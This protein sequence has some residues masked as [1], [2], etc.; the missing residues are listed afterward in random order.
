MYLPRMRCTHGPFSP[1]M[2]TKISAIR[3]ARPLR[4]WNASTS[5]PP[6]R[7]T[8]TSPSTGVSCAFLSPETRRTSPSRTPLVRRWRSRDDVSAR[9]CERSTP[10][11]RASASR[12]DIREAR[13]GEGGTRRAGGRFILLL[14]KFIL[15]GLTPETFEFLHH[16]IRK[17]RHLG[18]FA[19]LSLLWARALAGP[20]ARWHARRIGGALC[21]SIL[22][23]IV[24][25]SH[26]AFVPSRGASVMDVGI[27]TLGAVLGQGVRLVGL[28]LK[29]RNALQRMAM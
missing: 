16:G 18:E 10:Y 22:V 4:S 8:L 3:T 9:L 26:Q 2:R 21:L 12:A 23:V 25:E 28:M 27:D 1:V 17:L 13:K 7:F 19:I 20:G 11:H 5:T 6:L 29:R 24:D 15:P 14:L